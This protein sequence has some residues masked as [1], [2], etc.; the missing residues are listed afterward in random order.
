MLHLLPEMKR[1]KYACN[2]SRSSPI[3]RLVARGQCM[4]VLEIGN[5]VQF[6]TEAAKGDG[7]SRIRYRSGR[8]TML[9]G[10]I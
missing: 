4:K 10:V 7:R 2:K 6:F 1:I 3:W 9:P 8:S 5:E